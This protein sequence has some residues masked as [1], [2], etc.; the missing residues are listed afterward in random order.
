MN[1][2]VEDV[3]HPALKEMSLHQH[4]FQ[5][6]FQGLHAMTEALLGMAFRREAEKRQSSQWPGWAL[7]S[8]PPIIAGRSV[9][10]HTC[11]DGTAHL[12]AGF[13][14]SRERSV[15]PKSRKRSA[16]SGP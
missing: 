5:M 10:P 12:S 6:L 15:I 3:L 16:V 1:P 9:S 2:P 8:F 14:A 11:G 13:P 4:S 7:R